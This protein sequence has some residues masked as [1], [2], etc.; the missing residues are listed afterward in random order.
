M[1]S[2]SLDITAFCNKAKERSDAVV[3]ETVIGLGKR[4]VELS[5]VGDPTL[6]KSK[7][8][9]GYVG[10]RFRANWQ[11]GNLA[12][13]GI[14]MTRSNSIDPS[15]AESMGRIIEGVLGSIART[16]HYLVNNLPYAKRL[17]D[18]WS[19]QAPAGMV[20]LTIIEFKQIVRSAVAEG[21]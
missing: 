4:L 12:G 9:P 2:F 6:W 5:P 3:R 8:P 13:T 15:G 11:Y 18:G 7:P 16:R 1:S 17:E 14:P 19:G 21:K 20:G 10:G